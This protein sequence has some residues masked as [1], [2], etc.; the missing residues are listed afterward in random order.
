M[1]AKQ[2]SEPD[3]RRSNEAEQEP[4]DSAIPEP[5]AEVVVA[6]AGDP[7]PVLS[8]NLASAV[9]KKAK[10]RKKS[11]RKPSPQPKRKPSPQP[12]RKL[13]RKP[14]RVP[15]P[16]PK[17]KPS[18]Q[19]KR[20]LRRKPKSKPGRRQNA[21][22]GPKPKSDMSASDFIRSQP[23]TAKAK[24]VVAAGKAKGIKVSPGLVY[25]VRSTAK[26]RTERSPV[27]R[28]P[29]RKPRAVVDGEMAH[30]S[31][32]KKL[33]LDFGI[34]RARQQLDELERGLAELIR[35]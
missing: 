17:R 4:I 9:R 13:R 1:T 33:A 32:F 25:M 34:A 30:V 6:K 26:K 3:D 18:P 24:D 16:Q 12:K 23:A 20:K 5:A 29:G 14:K 31:T 22:P 19:P 21:R 8:T 10:G 11:K 7:G 2:N 28:K 15:S 27:K 35:G